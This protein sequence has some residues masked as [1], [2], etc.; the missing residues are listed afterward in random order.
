MTPAQMLQAVD[1]KYSLF[2]ATI[3]GSVDDILAA[4]SRLDRISNK[5]NSREIPDASDA[6]LDFE[7]LA[8]DAD[9]THTRSAAEADP[10]RPAATPEALRPPTGSFGRAATEVPP[11][12]TIAPADPDIPNQTAPTPNSAIQNQPSAILPCQVGL[13]EAAEDLETHTRK[14]SPFDRLTPEQQHA[15]YLLLEE[16][17]SS[18]TIADLLKLPPPDGLNFTTSPSAVQRFAKRYAKQLHLRSH[19]AALV[20]A[21]QY[22][23]QNPDPKVAD[24]C[25]DAATHS[26]LRLHL[27]KA[28]AATEA[29]PAKLRALSAVLHDLHQQSIAS[30]KLALAREKHAANPGPPR[31]SVARS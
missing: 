1:A 15:I 27:Y 14:K 3:G 21:I 28:A 11:L 13:R 30:G 6:D 22:L 7:E 23:R 31:S 18:Y 20:Q 24:K 5:K 25:I 12:E 26:L 19:N 17:H 4:S 9:V 8:C 16:G 2:K 10:K 29:D